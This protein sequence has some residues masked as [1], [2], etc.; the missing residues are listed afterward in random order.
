VL[1]NCA[2][3]K[4]RRS[5]RSFAIDDVVIQFVSPRW[6]SQLPTL[7]GPFICVRRVPPEGRGRASMV[8]LGGLLTLLAE[9]EVVLDP[10][11]GPGGKWIL[12]NRN[13]HW[14]SNQW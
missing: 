11:D 12:C 7:R 1:R 10:Q 4:D 6:S 3:D 2:S 8:A 14:E 5:Y 9:P 13:V